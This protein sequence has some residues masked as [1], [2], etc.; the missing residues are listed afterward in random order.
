M[1]RVYSEPLIIQL[2]VPDFS[3]PYNVL[4]LSCTIMTIGYSAAQ[5]LVTKRYMFVARKNHAMSVTTKLK[6]IKTRIMSLFKRT[7][8]EETVISKVQ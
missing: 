7:K 3:M 5:T 8:T 2:M 6:G 4:C 1:H